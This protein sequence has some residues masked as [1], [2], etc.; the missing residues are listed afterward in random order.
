MGLFLCYLLKSNA[1]ITV[2]NDASHPKQ[3]DYHHDRFH[4]Y[5][6]FVHDVRILFAIAYQ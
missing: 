2:L 1:A 4:Q 6:L 3:N 5:Q